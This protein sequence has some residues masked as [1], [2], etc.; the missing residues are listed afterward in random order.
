MLF[1]VYYRFHGPI[2]D[3]FAILMVGNKT[4]G[5]HKYPKIDSQT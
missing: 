2:W 1:P 5:T 3:T 4:N